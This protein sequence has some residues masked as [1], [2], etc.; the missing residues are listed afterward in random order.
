MQECS[1]MLVYTSIIDTWMSVEH[2]RRHGTDEKFD[3]Y[4]YIYTYF[5]FQTD[6]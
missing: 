3:T 5:N 1:E 4:I 6:L 2:A